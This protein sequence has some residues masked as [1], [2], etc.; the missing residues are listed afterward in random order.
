MY[1]A[2]AKAS[3]RK[4]DHILTLVYGIPEKAGLQ[5]VCTFYLGEVVRQVSRHVRSG[6]RI[7]TASDSRPTPGDTDIR[8]A[9][10]RIGTR[11]RLVDSDIDVPG[12]EYAAHVQLR[13]IVHIG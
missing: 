9:A 12:N 3:L 5:R 11:K 1:G 6:K 13:S 4:T 7:D 10:L 8:N 2:K